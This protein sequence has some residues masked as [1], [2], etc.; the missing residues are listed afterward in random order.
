MRRFHSNEF[1]GKPKANKDP[2][3]QFG[4][5]DRVEVIASGRTGVVTYSCNSHRGHHVT[6]QP[7]DGSPK[8]TYLAHELRP[9]DSLF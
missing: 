7:D 4:L 6:I 3:R 2:I 1:A 5:R 9:T 8:R